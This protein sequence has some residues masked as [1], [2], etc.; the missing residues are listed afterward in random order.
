[1]HLAHANAALMLTS[2]DDPRMADFVA[3]LDP[4]NATADSSPG[5]VWRLDGDKVD[6][7]IDEEAARIFG[8][9][10][11][12]FNMSV[13]ESVDALEQYTYKSNH[14]DVVRK[15]AKWFEKPTRSP[16]VLWWVEPGHLPS[17]AEAKSR[18]D[19]LWRDG[20]SREAFTFA[21]RYPPA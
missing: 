11:L 12:L 17:I 3:E 20:P 15:R 7:D 9:E 18:F 16:F 5:F 6:F 1:M 4:V 19:A 2:Y 21:N 13:W 10:N 14:I 8:I